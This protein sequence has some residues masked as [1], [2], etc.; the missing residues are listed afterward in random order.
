MAASRNDGSALEKTSAARSWAK[1]TANDEPTLP[2]LYGDEVEASAPA[3]PGVRD[4]VGTV[5]PRRL[6]GGDGSG[7]ARNAEAGRIDVGSI[8]GS[9]SPAVRF[10]TKCIAIANSSKVSR[11]SRSR[12][13]SSS[14]LSSSASGIFE[15]CSNLRAPASD[16]EPASDIGPESSDCNT[17]RKTPSYF[18]RTTAAHGEREREREHGSAKSIGQRASRE[19]IGGARKGVEGCSRAHVLT[20]Q[21]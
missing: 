13:A 5:A 6:V 9:G 7:G 4:G 17:E 8:S 19:P 3:R 16:T 10:V 15:R 1:L 20:C 18:L 12:S 21:G 11:P 14:T 2:A